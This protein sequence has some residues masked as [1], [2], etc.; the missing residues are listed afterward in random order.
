MAERHKFSQGPHI[1]PDS[2]FHKQSVKL[3]TLEWREEVMVW[4]KG[5]WEFTFNY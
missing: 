3:K 2:P 5:L 1:L 4:D